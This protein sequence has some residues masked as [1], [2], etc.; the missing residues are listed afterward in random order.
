MYIPIQCHYF[1]ILL[2]CFSDCA[3]C[4][5]FRVFFPDFLTFFPKNIV[6]FIC[7]QYSNANTQEIVHWGEKNG[8]AST[9][10]TLFRKTSILKRAFSVFRFPFS[11]FRFPFSVHL[12]TLN[13]AFQAFFNTNKPPLPIPHAL[14]PTHGF[15]LIVNRGVFT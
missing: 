11:V 6:F 14:L 13:Y 4:H 5:S 2:M 1:N 3:R 7:L 8:M 9:E 15:I 10:L 12:P